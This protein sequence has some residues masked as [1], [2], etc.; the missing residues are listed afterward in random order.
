[1][2]LIPLHQKPDWSRP[3]WITAALVLINL[4]VFVFYQGDDDRHLAEAVK[5]YHSS[6]LL[7][8]EQPLYE[9][10]RAEHNEMP[11]DF[12]DESE[13]HWHLMLDRGFD[14]YLKDYWQTQE[15]ADIQ[16]LAQWQKSR[17]AF[18]SER[19]QVSSFHAGLTPSEGR[20]WT[21]ATSVFLHGGWDHLV[22]NMVF[23]L[24]FGLTLEV[25]LGP[26]LYSVLYLVCGVA[27][28]GLHVLLH[29]SSTVPLIGASGAI[30]GLMG[31]YVGLYRFQ[32][33][34]FF[35]SIFFY[36]GEL[37]APALLVLPLWLCKEIYGYYF[38]DSNIAYMAHTGGLLAGA[39][40]ILPLRKFLTDFEQ[41]EQSKTN[42]E[43]V[44]SGLARLQAAVSA[45]DFD[46]A[47]ALANQ[48]C[49]RH[50]QNVQVWRK[51]FDLAK[52]APQNRVLDE[53][54]VKSV[55]QF[56]QSENDFDAWREDF[57]SMLREYSAKSPDAPALDGAAYLALAK[58]YWQKGWRERAEQ[59]L[60][61]A[62]A[63]NAAA[64]ELAAFVALC[65][66][67]YK[68]LGNLDRARYLEA[69]LTKPAQSN[70]RP[71]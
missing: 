42:N 38:T 34:R 64:D 59:L 67:E 41:E 28:G 29:S 36:F 19:N 17:L 2:I 8:L 45:L 54:M 10:Y 15:A 70:R 44:S 32:K 55:R 3:P 24:L 4:L 5:I 27:A 18:E 50:P 52:L 66:Q 21:Y 14:A 49:E 1:M 68:R 61:L 16:R 62:I 58:K 39:L 30:S 6:H 63:K 22:G 47:R 33:I 40:V 37:R 46:R 65:S 60:K 12:E 23:L 13:L 7:K 31:M 35:Y 11:A 26:L 53:T 9:R 20:W 43:E 69:F 25:A 57:E 48:L 71:V 51:R 56:I